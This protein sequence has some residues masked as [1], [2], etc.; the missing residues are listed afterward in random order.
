M[1][2]ANCIKKPSLMSHEGSKNKSLKN[3]LLLGRPLQWRKL[4]LLN[5]VWEGDSDHSPLSNSGWWLIGTK[6]KFLGCYPGMTTGLTPG[7]SHQR[8]RWV[9]ALTLGQWPLGCL[10]ISSHTRPRSGQT[11]LTSAT[12]LSSI[13][14]GTPPFWNG[15]ALFADVICP[16]TL[17]A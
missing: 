2:S 13:L 14:L 10:D 3:L 1:K 8:L 16:K 9:S 6:P 7:P 17:V 11:R 12:R 5:V 15:N 4:C